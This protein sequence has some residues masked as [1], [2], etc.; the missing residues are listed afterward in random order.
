MKTNNHPAHSPLT[1]RRLH[2]MR[3]ILSKAAAQRDG[4][5]IG[6][7]MSDAVKLINEVLSSDDGRD[8]FEE[9]FKFHYGN[10]HSIVK[11]HRANG[12]ANYRDP[13]VDLAWIAW[14]DSRAAML[15]AG[16]SPVIP[17]GWVMVPIEPTV[18]M[19]KAFHKANDEADSFVSPDHQWDAMLAAAPQQEVLL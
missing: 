8:Q 12:G 2:Q 1:S 11:L 10:E 4:G 6:Y 17:D 9:W 19:R 14:K 3:D 5:D 13:H 16:S 15:P 7:A 18:E